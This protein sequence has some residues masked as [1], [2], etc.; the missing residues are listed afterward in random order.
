MPK[1]PKSSQIVRLAAS[2]LA[3]VGLLGHGLAM[4]LVAV[5]A[6]PPSAAAQSGFPGL[7]EICRADGASPTA[8]REA[9][10]PDH[11]GDHHG[12]HLEGCP[13]CTAFAQ[14]GPAD[15]PHALILP[16][17]GRGQTAPPAATVLPPA[18]KELG[19]PQTRAPPATA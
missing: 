13:V 14:S 6:Q 9:P 11:P 1:R 2:A 18:A 10:S 4:L 19:R 15:L 12:G 3:A 8:G 16:L 7:A 17:G 5:L